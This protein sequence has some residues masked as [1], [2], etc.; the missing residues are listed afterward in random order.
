MAG[1]GDGPCWQF[2]HLLCMGRALSTPSRRRRRCS[3]LRNFQY[4]SRLCPGQRRCG[5]QLS[6][7]VFGHDRP[8]AV[9]FLAIMS[10]QCCQQ[11]SDAWSVAV[12]LEPADLAW[13]PCDKRA[14]DGRL[15]RKTIS[16]CLL[17]TPVRPPGTGIGQRRM[18]EPPGLKTRGPQHHEPKDSKNACVHQ[19]EDG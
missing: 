14:W 12:L 19:S 18:A 6:M 15:S 10:V 11:L 4:A 9:P 7:C 5:L 2:R 13:R 17:A 16:F 8:T 3:W 1:Q